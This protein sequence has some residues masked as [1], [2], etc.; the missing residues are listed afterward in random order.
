MNIPEI[1]ARAKAARDIHGADFAEDTLDL[2]AAYREQ[3][4]RIAEL[5]VL[6]VGK[7][8]DHA[9]RLDRN[10]K[11]ALAEEIHGHD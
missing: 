3:E 6:I 11:R 1:E 2:C 8:D 5:E 7:A 10:F 4:K 9:A